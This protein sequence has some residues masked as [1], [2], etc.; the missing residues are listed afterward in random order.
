[1]TERGEIVQ[2]MGRM[3]MVMELLEPFTEGKCV[4]GRRSSSGDVLCWNFGRG[5]TDT[6]VVVFFAFLRVSQNIVSASN[7]VLGEWIE[8]NVEPRWCTPDKSSPKS[9]RDPGG[10]QVPFF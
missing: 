6:I 2:V 7:L 1:M 3:C 4:G 9:Q 5:W 8:W 10:F